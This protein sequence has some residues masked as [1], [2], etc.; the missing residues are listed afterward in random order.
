MSLTTN[1]IRIVAFQKLGVCFEEKA[2]LCGID[3]SIPGQCT[4]LVLTR[5][6]AGCILE[7]RDV[8]SCEL[9]CRCNAGLVFGLEADV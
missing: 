5:K 4:E 7:E 3:D 6:C 2:V 9:F 1:Q 8:L